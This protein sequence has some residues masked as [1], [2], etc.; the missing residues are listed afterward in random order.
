MSLQARMVIA[1]M[2]A[3]EAVA[4]QGTVANNLTSAGT[5]IANAAP[6]GADL[7]RFTTVGASSGCILPAMNPGDTIQIFNAQATNALLLYPP[8]STSA[9]NLLSN[10]TAYSIAAATPFCNVSCITPTLYHA[11]QSA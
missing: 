9:I 2:S 4:S 8:N 3:T 6:L 7:N 5:T 11:M 1:G 10:G